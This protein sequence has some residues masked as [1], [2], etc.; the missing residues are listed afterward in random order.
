[1]IEINDKYIKGINNI[2]KYITTKIDH[3]T[4][5]RCKINKSLK[6]KL[7]ELKTEYENYNTIFNST[8]KH[9]NYTYNLINDSESLI[10]EINNF[11]FNI[12][13][14]I[15]ILLIMELISQL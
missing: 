9:K 12:A 13:T 1:M 15:M 3:I 7:K 2:I 5:C 11:L 10:N 14:I 4:I 8:K 6:T